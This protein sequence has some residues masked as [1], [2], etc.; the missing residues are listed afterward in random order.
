MSL[1]S[2]QALHFGILPSFYKYTL[3]AYLAITND[4]NRSLDNMFEI[5][6]EPLFLNPKIANDSLPLNPYRVDAGITLVRDITYEFSPGFLPEPAINELVG[7]KF[8]P[9]DLSLILSCFPLEWKNFIRSNSAPKDR[10]SISF[11]PPI[12]DIK[13]PLCKL[14]SKDF[15]LESLMPS[16]DVSSQKFRVYWEKKFSNLDWKF[17]L[18]SIFTRDS[19]RKSCDLQWKII[20]LAIPTVDRLA[21]H[22]IIDNPSCPRCKNHNETTLH[23]FMHCRPVSLLWVTVLSHIKNLDLDLNLVSLEQFIVIGFASIKISP[24][25]SPQLPSVI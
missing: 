2:L 17:I 3:R 11:T 20:Q 24:I 22:K 9:K 5:F 8:K 13:K 6:N 7:S 16:T 4:H 15:Y 14:S 25:H 12:K 19:D 10:F 23:L 1:I 21:R 18:N